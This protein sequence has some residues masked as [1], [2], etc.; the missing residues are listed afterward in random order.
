M[1]GKN[2]VLLPALVAALCYCTSPAAGAVARVGTAVGSSAAQGACPSNRDIEGVLGEAS[3]L[4]ERSQFEQA[5]GVL[6]PLV[7]LYC[8]PRVSLLFAA[9]TEEGGNVAEARRILE[10][11]HAKW[12]A[13][14]SIA[15]SLA[16]EYL[17][18]RQPGKAL[19]ALSDFHAAPAVP[20]Q[21]LEL[22]VVVYMETQHLGLAQKT[23]EVNYGAHPSVDSLLLLANTLQ[24]QGRYPDV[25]RLLDSKRKAYSSSPKFLITVAESEYDA[26]MYG[27]ARRDVERAITL[28][29]KSYA[30][31][32]I[33]GNVLVRLQ[34]PQ[35]AMKEYRA[36]IALD[37]SQPR[38]YFQLAMVLRSQQDRAGE[39]QAL[40][41]ALAADRDFAPAQGEIGRLLIEESHVQEAVT[42][43]VLATKINPDYEDAY[44]LLAQ[45]YA[46]LG[47]KDKSNAAVKRL[48]ALKNADRKEHRTRRALPLTLD[49]EA[50]RP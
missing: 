7:G 16:R 34:Q 19:N 23:A 18:E 26:Q 25:N 49:P 38:T 6:K 44:Y 12:P 14:A 36:A 40:R 9:A 3:A 21:E 28:D 32:Y 8:D 35:Q 47:E 39:E 46:K 11:A 20:E 15:T 29:P 4:M 30:A 33:F 31:H 2:A 27:A 42:H 17:E 45:A 50:V 5:E 22:A 48:M 41:G 43:L 10:R 13:S 37:P 1:L 24:L